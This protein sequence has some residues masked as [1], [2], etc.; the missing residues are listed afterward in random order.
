M[1]PSACHHPESNTDKPLAR[2]THSS[3]RRAQR[4]PAQEAALEGYPGCVVLM[5][6]DEQFAHQLYQNCI[7]WKTCP[8]RQ[9]AP[10]GVSQQGLT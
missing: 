3:G 4:R 6:H 7:I 10:A 2:A 9:E 1:E 5:T 8:V